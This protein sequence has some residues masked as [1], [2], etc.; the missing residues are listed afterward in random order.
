M[1]LHR[2]TTLSTNV[3]DF[4]AKPEAGTGACPG[5]CPGDVSGRRD[6]MC[7]G[8]GDDMIDYMVSVE[9]EVGAGIG[10]M[11]ASGQEDFPC[12]IPEAP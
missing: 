4:P 7:T 10:E 5:V 11:G 2:D 8:S 1:R 12:V 9:H 3:R 6:R